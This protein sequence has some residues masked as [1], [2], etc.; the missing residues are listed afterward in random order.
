MKMVFLCYLYIQLM[1]NLEGLTR[2][3]VDIHK[4]GVG[5][6]VGLFWH[7]YSFSYWIIRTFSGVFWCW[8]MLTHYYL[9]CHKTSKIFDDTFLTVIFWK[10][11]LFW[12]VDR[13]PANSFHSIIMW[14]Y[15]KLFQQ[16]HRS[17][18]CL[19]WK[20]LGMHWLTHI[21]MELGLHR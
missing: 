20:T 12:N 1:P 18:W 8:C 13:N 9:K 7:S 21:S 2:W 14:I 17:R 19:S 10:R 11:F 15:A 3:I 5:G 4:T 6:R 16:Y